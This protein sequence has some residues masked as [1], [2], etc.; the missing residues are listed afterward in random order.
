[1]FENGPMEGTWLRTY[2]GVVLGPNDC[3]AEGNDVGVS[4]VFFGEVV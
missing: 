3:V 4:D 1:M 2:D